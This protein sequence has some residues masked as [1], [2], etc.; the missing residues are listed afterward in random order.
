[1][2]GDAPLGARTREEI[3]E[4]ADGAGGGSRGA[5]PRSEG[6]AT[7]S[8][9]C[10]TISGPA[11]KALAEIRALLKT[12]GIKLDAPLAAMEARL[13][14]LEVAGRRS[15]A[16][17]LRR[18][19]RPQHGILHRLRLRAVGARR[20]RPGAGRGRR[21][22]RH[23][24]GSAGRGAGQS[25]PSAAPSAPS[26]CWPRAARGRRVHDRADARH[27]LQGPAAGASAATVS[28][29]PASR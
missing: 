23:A 25:A 4:R 7:S 26:A 5:A 12:A 13:A 11:P 17:A 20:G 28:P 2:V 1:M 3:V 18:P 29:T 16:R 21:P 22:L 24:A 10:W 6:R 15:G 8:P 9:S 27:S 14:A 19:F